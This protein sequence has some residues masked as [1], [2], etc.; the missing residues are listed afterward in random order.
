MRLRLDTLR[1]RFV[2]TTCLAAVLFLGVTA[3]ALARPDPVA[4]GAAALA[5]LLLSLLAAAWAARGVA[6][7]LR[8]LDDAAAGLLAGRFAG[9][10]PGG[11]DEIARLAERFNRLGRALA[12]RQAEAA[13]ASDRARSA[14][15]AGMSHELRTPLNAV[16]GMSRLL[17]TQRL[18][19]LNAKQADYL[20]DIAQAGEHLLSLI[21]DLLDL[22]T[23][24]SGRAGLRPA[25]FGLAAAVAAALASVQPPAEEKGVTL[26]FEPPA[27]DGELTTD[28]DRFR[29]VLHALLANAVQF[30]PRGGSVTVTYRWVS[31]TGPAAEEV[32]AAAAAAARVA[33]RDTG[34]GVPP[35][36]QAAIWDEFRRGRAAGTGLG[37]ARARRL[38]ALLGGRVW[39][40]SAPGRGSTFTFALPRRPP[41]AEAA[42]RGA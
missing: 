2:L 14:F 10:P 4:V 3:A 5:A 22:S 19:P 8:R 32:P 34:P 29:Q 25:P 21:S 27:A 15:L 31:G 6:R 26:H 16:I 13:E 12:E 11:P 18:G 30:T 7:P 41:T 9:V 17:A 24:E 39:L 23:A 40:D 37:L 28:P 36:E 20:H 38:A 33:V 35:E 42:P 1:A